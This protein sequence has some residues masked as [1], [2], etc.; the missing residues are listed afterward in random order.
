MDVR[1]IVFMNIVWTILGA[2]DIFFAI[3]H[4]KKQEYFRFGFWTMMAVSAIISMFEVIV[5]F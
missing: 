5:C 1:T 2:G 3:R 4:F